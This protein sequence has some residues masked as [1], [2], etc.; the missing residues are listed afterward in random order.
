MKEL[1]NASAYPLNVGLQ[2]RSI[3]CVLNV[4]LLENLHAQALNVRYL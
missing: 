2:F 1:L 3:S 4:S